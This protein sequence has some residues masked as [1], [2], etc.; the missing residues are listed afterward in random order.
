ME[1]CSV[2]NINS[3]ISENR[4]Q[5]SLVENEIQHDEFS[6]D[7]PTLQVKV[8]FNTE[9]L[10]H[11]IEQTSQFCQFEEGTI[12]QGIIISKDLFDQFIQSFS[13]LKVIHLFHE[14]DES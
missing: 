12:K 2:E 10:N 11:A 7:V 1:D 8:G 4:L 13:I 6:F 5:R 9:T 3:M 14:T